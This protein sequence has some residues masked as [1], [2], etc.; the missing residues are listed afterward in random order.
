MVIRHLK[1][2]NIMVYL[3]SNDQSFVSHGIR[4]KYM[5]PVPRMSNITGLTL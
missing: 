1:G 4:L 2:V 5:A 3:V